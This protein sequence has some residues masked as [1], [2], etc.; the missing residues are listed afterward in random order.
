MNRLKEVKE[1]IEVNFASLPKNP[2]AA[3]LTLHDLGFTV[4][5]IKLVKD[6]PNHYRK[7]PVI[8]W[9]EIVDEGQS[10]EDLLSYYWNVDGLAIFTG[11]KLRGSE[12]YIGALD[13]DDKLA[14]KEALKLLPRT[15]TERTP[16]GGF[17]VIFLTKKKPL[18]KQ[19]TAP[20]VKGEIFSV[21]G[22][23]QNGTPKLCVVYPTIKYTPVRPL[24][25]IIIDDLNKLAEKIARALGLVKESPRLI[26]A[27]PLRLDD[28][29]QKASVGA[30]IKQRPQTISPSQLFEKK[31]RPLLDIARE[32]SHY[33]AVHCPFHPP[34]THPSFVIYRNT[35]LA[36]D[37]HDMK[38][39]TMKGL[40]R[41]LVMLQKQKGGG[42]E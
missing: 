8:S 17:H 23:T 4:L 24:P 19:Y 42:V 35:W 37:F 21:L 10:K 7:V 29:L 22:E 32:S 28:Q 11:V 13:F 16:R 5:P 14:F 2:K 6:G 20:N 38:V 18:Y 40:Y 27:F 36:V 26:K 33:Y 34:D 41:S 3:A 39:Y 30:V 1:V 15:Y 12:Y 9:K 25:L 31:I